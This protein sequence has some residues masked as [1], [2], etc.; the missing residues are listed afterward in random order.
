MEAQSQRQAFH[1][2]PIYLAARPLVL[3]VGPIQIMVQW[4]VKNIRT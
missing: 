4:A 1:P 2:P 3:V